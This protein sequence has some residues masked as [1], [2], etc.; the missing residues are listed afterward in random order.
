MFIKRQSKI[1]NGKMRYL[2]FKVRNQF[3]FLFHKILSLARLLE[4][5][6]ETSIYT[7]SQDQIIKIEPEIQTTRNLLN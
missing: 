7:Q 2:N 3:S 4:R 5:M 1:L 6:K